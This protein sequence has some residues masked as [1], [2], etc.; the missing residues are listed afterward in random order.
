M[1]HKTDLKKLSINETQKVVFLAGNNKQSVETILS[2]R[3]RRKIVENWVHFKATELQVEK[4]AKIQI[5]V[6]GQKATNIWL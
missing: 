2:L 1:R 6:N 3:L 4:R 5:K